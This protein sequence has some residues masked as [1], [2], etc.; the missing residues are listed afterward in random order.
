M[1]LTMERAHDLSGDLSPQSARK[2]RP[3]PTPKTARLTSIGDKEARE[4]VNAIT[5]ETKLVYKVFDPS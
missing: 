3:V 5:A 4:S 2:T 1:D